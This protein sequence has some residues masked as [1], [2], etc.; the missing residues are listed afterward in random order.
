MAYRYLV[1]VAL[2][3]GTQVTFFSQKAVKCFTL[4]CVHFTAYACRTLEQ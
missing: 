4:Y 2:S 1:V 3:L